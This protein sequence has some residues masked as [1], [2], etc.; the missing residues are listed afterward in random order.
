MERLT[1]N[2][3]EI[4]EWTHIYQTNEKKWTDQIRLHN[5][6]DADKDRIVINFCQ[7]KSGW[8]VT[9]SVM[10]NAKGQ[11]VMELRV[12]NTTPRLTIR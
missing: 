3:K 7:R 11:Q 5:G 12:V 6:L 9:N 1:G 8:H 10:E 4:N 2:Y